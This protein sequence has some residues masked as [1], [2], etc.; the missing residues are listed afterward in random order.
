MSAWHSPEGLPRA[1]AAVALYVIL[2][3]PVQAN[4]LDFA[5]PGFPGMIQMP[6]ARMP[7]PGTVGVTV[8]SVQ[9][10]NVLALSAQPFEWLNASARY[11][12]ITDRDYCDGCSQ[13]FLDKSFDFSMRLWRQSS[14]VPAVA[15]GV[16]DLGGTGLFGGEYLVA[17]YRFFDWYASAG[18]GWGRMGSANDFPNPAKKIDSR[19]A[20]REVDVSGSGGEPSAKNW[21]SGAS[22]GIF[23]GLEWRPQSRPWVFTLE[24]EGNDYSSE[25][26]G[27]PIRSNTRLNAGV[28]YQLSK[29][30]LM[31][32]SY[33]RGNTFAFQV[34][35]APRLGRDRRA[36]SRR[37]LPEMDQLVTPSYRT[38][39][40]PDARK[41]IDIQALH[42]DLRSEGIFAAAIDIDTEAAQIS[43]W[44]YNRFSNL[45]IDG[46]RAAGRVAFP[47]LPESIQSIRTINLV[48]G[49]ETLVLTTPRSAIEDDAKGLGTREEVVAATQIVPTAPQ[50]G[51]APTFADLLTYPAVV[52][53]M[54]PALRSNIGGL[55]GHYLGEFLLKPYASVQLTP[56]LGITGKLAVQVLGDFEKLKPFIRNSSSLPHVRSDNE[57]YQSSSG[58]VYIDQLEANY[59]FALAPEWYGRV[60]AGLTDEFFGGVG[61]EILRRPLYSRIAYGFNIN[62]MQ[63]RDYDLRLGF[64]DYRVSTGHL[65]LYYETPF[66][67]VIVKSSIGRYLAKDVGAT[68]QMSKRFSNGTEFGAFATKTNVSAEEF[69]EGSFDKGIFIRVPL[70]A[71]ASIRNRG[72]INFDYRF[73]SRDGGQKVRDGRA[74]YDVFG[75]ENF[76]AQRGY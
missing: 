7:E 12:A 20:R 67:G 45:P 14:Y 74:L 26:A 36:V 33:Q 34:V 51:A 57:I 72:S 4:P 18:L 28:K 39:E 9:P 61:A 59:V 27:N 24:W 21:F 73:L 23:G 70:E 69:G 48:A 55:A 8:S 52:Y 75:Q 11:T 13:S 66:S 64:R 6:T 38:V 19:L 22:V 31:G 15:L 5:Y 56:Q 54:D 10:Y 43:L 35:I 25:A 1:I 68:L 65:T 40:K 46:Q 37:P 50:L 29:S 58:P 16:V 17:T 32:M 63:Q 2:M 71:L 62:Y 49:V 44:Q 76:G 47:Y 42:Q 53:G 30:A 41:G 3:V 60:S